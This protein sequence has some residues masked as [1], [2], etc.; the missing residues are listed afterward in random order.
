MYWVIYYANISFG[1]LGDTFIF[2]QFVG[3]IFG[4]CIRMRPN[5]EGRTSYRLDIMKFVLYTVSISPHQIPL[6]RELVKV[7]GEE[8]FRYIYDRPLSEERRRL[9]WEDV[10]DN[11]KW[12]IRAYEEFNDTCRW[13]NQADVVLTGLRRFDLIRDRIRRGYKTWYMSERWFKP[14]S[15]SRL[16]GGF[17]TNQRYIRLPGWA[18]LIHPK[19]LNMAR[20]LRDLSHERNTNDFRVFPIGIHAWR[21]M[22][23]IGVPEEKM[24]MWGYFVENSKLKVERTRSQDE[25]RVLWVG[26]LLGWKRVD[27]IVRAI[28]KCADLQC[29]KDL[30]P[31]ITLDIYGAG[32]EERRLKKFAARYGEIIKFHPTVP[33]E[34]VRNL[35]RHHDVYVLASDGE[36]GWGAALNEALEEG[37]IV[38]GTHEAGSS[39]TILPAERQFK[40]GDSSALSRLLDKVVRGY[41]RP[42]GIGEW[43]VSSAARKLL[44]L[45]T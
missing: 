12:V 41:F 33:I 6:A 39:G 15:V 20:V 22:R 35:M 26:R 7:L 11:E 23:I 2:D 27:T 4:V 9:G 19:Y 28:G 44:E 14:I 45:V 10:F 21:D 18:R 36:E 34:E 43:S 5:G 42:T 24:T 30:M 40:A 32:P 17:G 29:K 13:L 8:N 38:L 16:F 31:R 37:M 1:G 3:G 25:F